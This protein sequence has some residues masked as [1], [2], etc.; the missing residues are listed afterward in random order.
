[1]PRRGRIVP[2]LGR[3]E[4]REIFQRAYRIVYRVSKGEVYI[5]TVRHGK[6]ILDA[7]EIAKKQLADWR[8][9][10]FG[11]TARSGSP[12]WVDLTP[13]LFLANAI[14]M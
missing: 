2:E 14:D 9:K 3:P 12:S 1:M 4:V 7:G 6:R 5:L 10:E 13:G 8:P 11:P